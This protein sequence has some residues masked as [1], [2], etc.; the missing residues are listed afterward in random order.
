MT[1]ITPRFRPSWSALFAAAALAFTAM[2]FP[3]PASAYGLGGIIEHAAGYAIGGIVAHETERQFLR[4][5]GAPPALDL[6]LFVEVVEL[7]GLSFEVAEV[8]FMPPNT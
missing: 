3:V 7:D 8:H 5:P 4:G 6:E 1:S 2:A